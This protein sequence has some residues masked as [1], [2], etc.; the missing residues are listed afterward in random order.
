MLNQSYIV[1]SCKPWNEPGFE[2][3]KSEIEADWHWVSTS[4]QLLQTLE[5]CKP[6]YVFFLHWNWYVPNEIWQN[7][8]CVCFHMTDVPY[9]R[10]GSPLQNLITAG[11]KTT[12]LTALRMV[13]QMDAGPVYTRREL[14]LNGRAEL[15]YKRAGEIS[16]DVIR[17]IIE[18]KPIPMPQQ[19]EIVAFKRRSPAQSRL[20]DNGTLEKLYD[21]IRMLDAPSYPLAFIEH[22][23]YQ[24]EFDNAALKG[25]EVIANVKIR[26]IKPK[27]L[28][29]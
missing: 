11:H 10:G 28:E 1:A 14:P 17:W 2:V 6:S 13:A 4:E 21:H 23:E 19:G 12:K 25:D 27:K 18:K 26:K 24:I 3:L 29:Y 16:F 7:L 20:P 5:N 15:I 8:E 22:G 9:G